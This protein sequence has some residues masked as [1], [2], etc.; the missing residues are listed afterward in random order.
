MDNDFDFHEFEQT[1]L[2]PSSSS[3]SAS[4]AKKAKN[5]YQVFFIN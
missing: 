5:E 3:Y 1:E 2:K 4:N